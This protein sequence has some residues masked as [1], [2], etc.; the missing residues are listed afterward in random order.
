[1]LAALQH[2]VADQRDEQAAHDPEGR[3]PDAE[4]PAP[5]PKFLLSQPGA[6]R[7][8]GTSWRRSIPMRFR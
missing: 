2:V 1:V 4:Q 7:I 3:E 6:T 5:R 8:S